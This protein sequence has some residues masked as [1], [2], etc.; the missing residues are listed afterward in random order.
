MTPKE[1]FIENILLAIEKFKEETGITVEGILVSSEDVTRWPD[2]GKDFA[3]TSIDLR[4][5]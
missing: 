2:L 4:M 1:K 5:K 3:I